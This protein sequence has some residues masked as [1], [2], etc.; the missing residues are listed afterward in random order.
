MNE[1][2]AI[3]ILTVSTRKYQVIEATDAIIK[4]MTNGADLS[5]ILFDCDGWFDI[6]GN[7]GSEDHFYSDH[8]DFFEDA[9][10]DCTTLHQVEFGIWAMA[11]VRNGREDWLTHLII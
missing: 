7:A 9:Y 1:A 3:S 8:L 11:L 6:Y 5:H 4:I 2:T 10:H